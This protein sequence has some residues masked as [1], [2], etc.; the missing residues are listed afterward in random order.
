MGRAKY[1]IRI[2]P[3]PA[4]MERLEKAAAGRWIITAL[5]FEQNGAK[6]FYALF[7]MSMHGTSKQTVE[8]GPQ[9][10]LERLQ[11]RLIR[12]IEA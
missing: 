1:P 4:F 2:E 5:V 11:D 10:D 6:L 3:S 7:Y 9:E 12:F 8:L